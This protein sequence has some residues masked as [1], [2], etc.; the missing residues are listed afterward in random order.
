MSD[1][2]SSESSHKF[3]GARWQ[4]FIENVLSFLQKKPKTLLPFEEVRSML[5]LSHVRDLGVQDVPLDKIVGSVG[6]YEDFT[7]EFLPRRDDQE[8][9]WR[10]IYDLSTSM[11]GFPPVE[12]LKVGDAYFVR[13]GN[14][15]V[16]VA[17]ANDAKTIEAYVTEYF[18]PVEVSADDTLDELLI[19]MGAANFAQVTKLDE[20]RP[21]HNIRLTNPGRYKYLLEH[22][23]MHK[24]YREIE[25]QCEISWEEA[26][27]SWYDNVYLPLVK[28]IRQRGILE[29]FP[30]RTEADLYAWVVFH[31]QALEERYGMGQVDDESVV[32]ALEEE[33]TASPLKK[34][35]RAIKRKIDPDSLPPKV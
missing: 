4:V 29:R 3:A 9:R 31:R 33:A 1:M 12:L 13:D 30:G 34:V 35:E 8:D 2:L 15:R 28:E 7:R 32:T 5:N 21:G 25:C 6:R 14:H 23:A 18:S 27:A 16:S 26:V 10:Q 17:R 11:A 20:L 22:I 19:K 24:Y